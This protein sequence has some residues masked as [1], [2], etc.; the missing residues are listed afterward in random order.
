MTEVAATPVRMKSRYWA[1]CRACQKWIGGEDILYHGKGNGVTHLTTEECDAAAPDFAVPVIPR[2]SGEFQY[3]SEHAG[4]LLE[5]HPWTFAKTMPL[6]PHFW[7]LQKQW[8]NQEDFT[9]CVIMIRALGEF[10]KFKGM[11]FTKFDW[12]GYEYW[13]CAPP[14]RDP[15]LTNLINRAVLQPTLL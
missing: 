1:R 8:S 12:N 15:S 2:D 10:R 6:T 3:L 4:A 5:A 9:W 14:T 7:T 11:G 13:T